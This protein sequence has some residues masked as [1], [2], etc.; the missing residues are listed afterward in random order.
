MT[1][2]HLDCDH[3]IG[4]IGADDAAQMARASDDYTFD[5]LAAEGMK[6][7]YCPF[8]GEHFTWKNPEAE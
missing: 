6:F 4:Y 1:K 8:C 7:D 2:K 3:L 5:D